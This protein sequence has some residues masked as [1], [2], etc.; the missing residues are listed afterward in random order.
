MSISVYDKTRSGARGKR[1]P[2]RLY[3][4]YGYYSPLIAR[5]QQTSAWYLTPDGR[6]VEVTHVRGES[7]WDGTKQFWEFNDDTGKCWISIY[8]TISDLEPCGLIAVY[9]FKGDRAIGGEPIRGQLCWEHDGEYG[10]FT[11]ERLADIRLELPE[12]E[13]MGREHPLAYFL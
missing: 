6:E 12:F 8:Q 5:L 3:Q 7:N 9:K 13:E 11:L 4:L 10:P 1:R 2:C